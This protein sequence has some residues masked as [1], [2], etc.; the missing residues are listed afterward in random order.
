MDTVL[1]SLRCLRNRHE[2]R[3]FRSVVHARRAANTANMGE[4]IRLYDALLGIPST[5]RFS[6]TW[7]VVR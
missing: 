5:F 3:W 2:L 6:L 1:L 4:S 7:R